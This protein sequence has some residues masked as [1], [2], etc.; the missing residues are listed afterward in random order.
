MDE[1]NIG[2]AEVSESS[3][4]IKLINENLDDTLN[5]VSKSMNELNSVWLSKGAETLMERFLNFSKKFQI[6][7]ETI[8]TYASFLDHTVSSYDSLESTITANASNF[9]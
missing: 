1:I 5:Y 2:L 7:S 9:E 8:D 4:N 3:K 6:E